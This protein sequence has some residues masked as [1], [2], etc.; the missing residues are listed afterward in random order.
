MVGAL[1]LAA[2]AYAGFGGL[3]FALQS[4][5]VYYPEVGREMIAT[6]ADRGL[7]YEEIA[8][9]TSD[10]ETLVA[11]WV[12]ASRARATVLLFHGNAGNISHRIDYLVMFRELGYA[13]FIVDYRGYGKSTGRPSEQGTYR[14]A[15]A[16]WAWLEGRGIPESN[17]VLFGESLG[18]GVAT[19]IA[20][21]RKPRAVVLASAFTSIPDLAAQIYPFLPVRL[22]TRI[23]YDNIGRLPHIDAP[24]LVLHSPD[25]EIVPYGHAERLYAAARGPKR[26]VRLAGGH[27]EG[28]VFRRAEWVRSLDEFLRE[29]AP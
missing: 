5:L 1:L 23:H 22:L 9:A 20:L 27:N 4:S 6:P 15:E 10:G 7:D 29:V 24:V 2:A 3:L 14:D 19:W 26:L 28:F 18:A 12:P 16:A 17:I 8:L 21:H 13:T 11:W 25:D